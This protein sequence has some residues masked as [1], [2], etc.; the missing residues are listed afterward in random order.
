MTN[1]R[2]LPVLIAEVSNTETL[3]PG[4][5]KN[6]NERKLEHQRLCRQVSKYR[7]EFALLT[8]KYGKIN[9]T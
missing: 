3:G 4:G 6:P 2:S 7:A 1:I 9:R 8:S 5:P